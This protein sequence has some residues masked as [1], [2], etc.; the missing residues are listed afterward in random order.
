MRWAGKLFSRIKT[1]IRGKIKSYGGIAALIIYS[2]L[3]YFEDKKGRSRVNKVIT[4][5]IYFTGTRAI[6]IISLVA[7]SLGV[8]TVLQAFHWF[9]LI[10][11]LET[12]GLVL[13]MV[14]VR[15]LGPIFTA[16]II[17]SRSATAIAA[18]IGTMMVNDEVNAMEMLGIDTLKFIVFPRIAGMV[19]AGVILTI[20]FN[21]IALIGG[22]AVGNIISGISFEMFM[23]YV[24]N[25]ITF[26]DI[27]A[28]ILKSII[29]S[30]FISAISVYYGFQAFVS[31]QVPQVATNAVVGS[32][33]SLF[34]LDIL[35]TLVFYL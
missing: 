33:F 4:M 25:S 7:L 12:V 23:T 27:L 34:F 18:E 14:I 29:F 24:M 5:Q 15:E 13:N 2:P 20:Y 26:M 8:V 1:S 28:S 22:F 16:F 31:T 32:I 30:I 11:S 3:A 10:G 19:I 9:R 17:L 21:A 6:K 35:V